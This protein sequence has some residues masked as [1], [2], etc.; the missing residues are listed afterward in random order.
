MRPTDSDTA[1]RAWIEVYLTDIIPESQL[2]SM[3]EVEAGWCDQSL[4]WSQESEVSYSESDQRY[5]QRLSRTAWRGRRGD[6][7]L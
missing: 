5:A 4:E 6:G 2:P 7:R 3:S 1:R